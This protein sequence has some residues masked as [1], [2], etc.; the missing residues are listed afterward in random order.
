L[1]DEAEKWA[2][3]P[4]HLFDVAISS[5]FLPWAFKQN[6]SSGRHD[7]CIDKKHCLQNQPNI[8]AVM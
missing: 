3:P 4:V 7:S 5:D 2:S 1:V 8:P 6:I